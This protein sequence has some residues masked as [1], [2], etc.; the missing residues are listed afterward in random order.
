MG[1]PDHRPEFPPGDTAR[2]TDPETDMPRRSTNTSAAYLIGA[3]AAAPSLQGWDPEAEAAFLDAVL[4]LDGVSGLEVRSTG[5][6]HKYD[7][8]W[9]LN[10]LPPTADVVL[11][12]LPGTMA[13]LKTMPSFGIASTD[14]AGRRAAVD[15]AGE[16]LR[17]V[18]RLNRAVGRE[19]V[20]AVQIH[21]APVHLSGSSSPGA[22]AASLAELASWDWG[23]AQLVIEHCDTAVRPGA[24]EGIPG[25]QSRNGSRHQWRRWG[26]VAMAV[27][28]G[29]TVIGHAA[30]RPPRNRSLSSAMPACSAASPF[31]VA[32]MWTPATVRPGPMCTYR[33]HRLGMASRTMA[34]ESA[35]LLTP[36]RI[37]ASLAAAGTETGFR[38]VKFAA[39]PAA[40]VA[41]RIAAIS[42]A[43][44]A[45]TGAAR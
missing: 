24:G 13:R 8:A 4:A 31:R 33:R 6:L 29:R 39:P 11:T 5:A 40:G 23:Q 18:G 19:S 45:V 38:A 43:L 14:D 7:E 28:W 1:V 42:A 21:T 32:Q 2:V 37:R 3:Y 20:T 16:A 15:F 35:S 34:S 30:P 9:F 44:S 27:N 12:L 22:L 26:P 36:G 10:R 41:A 25:F 17:A